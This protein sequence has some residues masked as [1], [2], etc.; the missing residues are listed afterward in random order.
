MDDAD[1]EALAARN[2]AAAAALEYSHVAL[3]EQ[4]DLGLRKLELDVFWDPRTG[5]FPVG[6]VQA[7]DMNSLCSPLADCLAQ[8][9]AWSDDNPTHAPVWI[10][11]NAKD[12][13][14]EGLPDPAPFTAYAF[15][16][17]DVAVTAALKDRLITPASV[18][19]GPGV[20]VWPS[21]REAR[22]QFLLILDE[23]GDKRAAYAAR[24]RERPMFVNVPPEH[25]AAAIMV[26]NDPL[27]DSRRIRQLVQA[28]YMVRTRADADTR[29]ARSNDVTRRDAAF[30][31]GA[32]AVSTDYYRPAAHFGTDYEVAP[33]LSC[34]P[35]N[36]PADCSVT[37]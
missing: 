34:N 33:R 29:E 22:G 16:A 20:P 35:V 14:I 17:L 23:G 12:R 30:A 19:R 21:L 10:S 9:V 2:P 4:L 7:I 27:R 25:A 1:V 6:H 37:D 24:W 31:S 28:G 13:Q 5:S 26:V 8:I 18:K 3:A 11:F 15:A 32:Q 36:A